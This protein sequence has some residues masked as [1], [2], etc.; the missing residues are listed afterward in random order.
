MIKRTYK[1][2]M[3]GDPVTITYVR[4][5]PYLIEWHVDQ[6]TPSTASLWILHD[7]SVVQIPD[8]AWEKLGVIYVD[9]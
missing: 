3:T 9:S 4:A 1:H 8:D 7:G 6:K 5:V 2:A